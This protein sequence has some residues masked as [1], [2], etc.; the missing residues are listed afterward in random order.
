MKLNGTEIGGRKIKVDITEKPLNGVGSLLLQS[1]EAP[2]V[3]NPYILYVGKLAKT[4]ASDSLKSFFAEKR[5]VLGAK[6][7]QVLETSK[8]SGF[9]FVSFSFEEEVEVAI[10]SFNDAG[11]ANLKM[12]FITI[13]PLIHIFLINLDI[14]VSILQPTDCSSQTPRNR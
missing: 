8:S 5:D 14:R 2:F 4:V 11:F 13:L 12:G 7:S 10:S 1:D 3:D 6:V 9:G